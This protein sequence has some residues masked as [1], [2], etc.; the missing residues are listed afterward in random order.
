[1]HFC[2]MRLSIDKMRIYM[3]QFILDIDLNY[4]LSLKIIKATVSN[5]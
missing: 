3:N 2:V 1:M 5:T 4:L